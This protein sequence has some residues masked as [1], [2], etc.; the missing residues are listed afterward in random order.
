MGVCVCVGVGV[1]EGDGA[2]VLV[3]VPV[4]LHKMGG[5]KKNSGGVCVRG[6]ALSRRSA[7]RLVGARL[8]TLLCPWVWV[9]RREFG[10]THWKGETREECC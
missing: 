7:T 4:R 10:A 5:G 6:R 2:I 8:L 9:W 1:E 3:G